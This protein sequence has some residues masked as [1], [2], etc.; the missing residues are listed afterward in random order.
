M[1]NNFYIKEIAKRGKIKIFVVDGQKVR[2]DVDKEFTN[3]GQHFRF[4]CIPKY[5]F[6]LDKEAA[7]DETDFFIDHLLI[8]WGEMKNGKSYQEACVKAERKELSERKKATKDKKQ[9]PLHIKLIGKTKDNLNIFLID[10]NQVRTIY[11]IE[12]T[13]GGHD[14]VYN[15]V[16]KNEV[17][18]DNDLSQ[19]ERKYVIL[20][21]LFERSLMK[22][23]KMSYN[24]AHNKASEIEWQARH[25]KNILKEESEKLGWK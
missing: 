20:H 8:E 10:G 23:K 22:N 17:W 7:K 19:S 6:W 24:N 16:P 4:K 11:D 18:I 2:K 12:F 25:D 5:E 3:F 13:E 21:E 14:F 9:K 15:Y 1:K